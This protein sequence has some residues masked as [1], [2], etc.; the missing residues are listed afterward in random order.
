VSPRYSGVIGLKRRVCGVVIFVVEVQPQISNKQ[1]ND[2]HNF[3]M[4]TP[5]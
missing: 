5:E 3:F 2:R 1:M 4:I